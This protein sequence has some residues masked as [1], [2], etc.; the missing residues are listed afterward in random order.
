MNPGG[1]V[2]IGVYAQPHQLV[3]LPTRDPAIWWLTDLLNQL[4]TP[5][6]LDHQDWFAIHTTMP[7]QRAV[8]STGIYPSWIPKLMSE[9]VVEIEPFGHLLTTVVH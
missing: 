9:L 7:K 8:W 1:L 6:T 4:P 5:L 3:S 2:G